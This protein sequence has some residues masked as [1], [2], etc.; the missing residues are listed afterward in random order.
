MIL[1]VIELSPP[2][3]PLRAGTWAYWLSAGPE[4]VP[5]GSAD[6]TTG[7]ERDLG[8]SLELKE[9]CV[10]Y[11]SLGEPAPARVD[12]QPQTL[13]VL[14]GAFVIS[15]EHGALALRHPS[16]GQRGPDA[17]INQIKANI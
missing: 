12:K 3:A 1:L 6:F 16:A 10:L 13:E 17:S 11:R 14:E 9:A 5:K 15:L 4:K 8:I 7:R 2:L